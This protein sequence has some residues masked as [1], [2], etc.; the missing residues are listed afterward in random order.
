MFVVFIELKITESWTS[1]PMKDLTL[2]GDFMV[3]N[4]T[5][6]EI[7]IIEPDGLRR[8]LSIKQDGHYFDKPEYFD[9]QS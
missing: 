6:S 1:S 8:H 7:Q 2:K 4:G 9:I 5:G 3:S